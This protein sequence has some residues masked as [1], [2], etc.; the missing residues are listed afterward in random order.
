MRFRAGY[1]PGN[2]ERRALME[3]AV[4][5]AISLAVRGSAYAGPVAVPGP[6]VSDAAGDWP[7]R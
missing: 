7:N 4:D 5:M 2:A 3:G 1:V 6:G